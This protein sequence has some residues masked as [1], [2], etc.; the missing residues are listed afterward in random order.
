ME[1]KRLDE[2]QRKAIQAIR[3]GVPFK[4][5]H[6]EF[7][8][9]IDNPEANVVL[10]LMQVNLHI[11]YDTYELEQHFRNWHPENQA[12]YLEIWM[13]EMIQEL[14]NLGLIRNV[15]TRVPSPDPMKMSLW[16]AVQRIEFYLGWR[17]GKG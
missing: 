10:S 16:E 3:D 8:T 14:C 12:R 6:T 13:V 9:E 2:A 7:Q 11:I 15:Y 1:Q 4:T 17:G 5:V